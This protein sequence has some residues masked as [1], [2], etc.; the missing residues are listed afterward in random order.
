VQRVQSAEET[1]ANLRWLSRVGRPECEACV[2]A[3][4]SNGLRVR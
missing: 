3:S 1:T 2:C 4:P